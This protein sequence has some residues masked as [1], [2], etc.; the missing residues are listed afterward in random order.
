MHAQHIPC[1]APADCLFLQELYKD[2][3]RLFA[4]L[5]L[6][7]VVE[8]ST[9]IL[10]GGLFRAP[11]K[12]QKGAAQY[13]N[14]LAMPQHIRDKLQTGSLDDLRKASKGGVDPDPDGKLSWG[15]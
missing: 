15:V 10:H 14:L 1:A 2:V 5:P 3:L 11:P 7:A 8:G 13:K 9:L 6:A 12:K 4:K